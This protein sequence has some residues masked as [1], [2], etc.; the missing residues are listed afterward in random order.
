MMLQN[1]ALIVL[2]V[3]PVVVVGAIDNSTVTFRT[4]PCT[5]AALIEWHTSHHL[6]R[7][8][9]A[10]CTQLVFKTVRFVNLREEITVIFRFVC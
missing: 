10:T 9:A 4:R 6:V 7:V 1:D 8:E 5:L 2:V 3:H